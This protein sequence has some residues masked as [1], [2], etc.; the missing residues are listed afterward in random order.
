MFLFCSSVL[1]LAIIHL[2]TELVKN[3]LDVIPDLNY[4]DIINMRN[5]LYQVRCCGGIGDID[6]SASKNC[7]TC[8]LILILF[9][10]VSPGQTVMPAS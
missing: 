3:L 5:D 6:H 8:C 4:N 7:A 2:H 10:G 9:V 1:H